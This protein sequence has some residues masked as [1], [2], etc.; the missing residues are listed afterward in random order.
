MYRNNK[1]DN[2]MAIF[3]THDSNGT[4]GISETSMFQSP[5]KK[6]SSNLE[7]PAI[8]NRVSIFTIESTLE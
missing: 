3:N 8:G 1:K 4:T 6:G 7:I 2:S 5:N